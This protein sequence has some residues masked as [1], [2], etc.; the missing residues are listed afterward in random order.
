MISLLFMQSVPQSTSPLIDW[1]VF[2]SK[3]WVFSRVKWSCMD[4]CVHHNP[5]GSHPA[6]AAPWGLVKPHNSPLQHCRSFQHPQISFFSFLFVLG[7]FFIT[8]FPK[9]LVILQPSPPAMSQVALSSEK[10]ECSPP[11]MRISSL[12]IHKKKRNRSH[13]KGLVWGSFLSP[14]LQCLTWCRLLRMAQGFKSTNL[15]LQIPLPKTSRLTLAKSLGLELSLP[16]NRPLKAQPPGSL[17]SQWKKR[18]RIPFFFFF[19]LF[20]NWARYVRK[21]RYQSLSGDISF[22][23]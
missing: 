8:S 15:G 14:E 23:P 16:V 4:H 7:F 20:H 12:P 21:K 19:S 17:C 13:K 10:G 5:P 22:S 3:K 9:N 11:K 2:S 6:I 18:S 1:Q